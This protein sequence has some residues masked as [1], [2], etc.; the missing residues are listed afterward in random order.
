VNYS[1]RR[2]QGFLVFVHARSLYTLLVDARLATSIDALVNRML[3]RLFLHLDDMVADEKVLAKVANEYRHVLVTKTA[4]RSVLGSMTD[5]INHLRWHADKQIQE[6]GHVDLG[7]IE[8]R[9]NTI[10]QRP[11]GWSVAVERFME[12]CSTL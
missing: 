12:L 10:P 8:A 6:A 7:D 2:R 3:E 9:L 11:I 4:D 5:L 1:A